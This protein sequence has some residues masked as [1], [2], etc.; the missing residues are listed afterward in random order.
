MPE[1]PPPPPTAPPRQRT[2][3]AAAVTSWNISIAKQIERHK[4]YPPSALGRR[5]SG[6]ARV[7]FAID[8][9]G[10]VIDRRI[11][12]S[13]GHAALDQEAI[14][15]LERAQ[16]FPAPPEELAGERFEFTVPVNF[17]VK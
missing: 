10:H 1:T 12:Q 17:T 4:G 2:A 8:R 5:E 7:A 3:S 16:P 15:T 9:E 14:A 6:V 13:S 11:I